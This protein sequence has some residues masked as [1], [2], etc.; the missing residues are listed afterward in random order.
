LKRFTLLFQ[1]KTVFKNPAISQMYQ[2]QWANPPQDNSAQADHDPDGDTSRR[3]PNAFILYSQAMRSSVRQANPTL[4]NTEVSRLLGKL[5]KDVP[6]EVKLQYKQ[7]ASKAQEDFKQEHPDYTYRKAR[8]KRALN[9]LLTKSNQ[10]FPTGG[11]PP[12]PSMAAAMFNPANP[13]M[14]QMY[15]QAAAGAAQGQG[16]MGAGFP[17]MGMPCMAAPQGYPNMPGYPP[18]GDPNQGAYQYQPK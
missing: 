6:A 7:Q 14:M 5:W 4:S 10:A 1:F 11:F 17:N 2:Q 9:E 12:D 15:A 16:Q 18:M 8:R 13:Y 3:P